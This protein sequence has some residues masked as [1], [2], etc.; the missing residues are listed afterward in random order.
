ML[1]RACVF[2]SGGICG[3]CSALRCARGAEHRCTIFLARVGPVRIPQKCIG[4]PYTE[5]VFLHPTA[6]AGHIVHS[7]AS[8]ARNVD[9]LFFMFGWDWCSFHKKLIRTSYVKLVFLHPV[10]YAGHVVH[11]SA[12]GV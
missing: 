1:R 9:A 11:Y 6:S 2:A 8:R 3:S 12:S 4:T 5:F 7:G 10:G